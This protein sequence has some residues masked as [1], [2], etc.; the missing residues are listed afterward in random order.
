MKKKK[1]VMSAKLTKIGRAYSESVKRK[2]VGEI[3][4]GLLSHREASKKYGV[5]RKSIGN[6]ITQLSLLNL[7]PLEIAR[8]T[9][10]D[11]KEDNKNRILAKQVLDLTKELEKSKLRISGLETMIA[12]SEQEL[13]IKIRKKS[14]AKQSRK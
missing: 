3:N 14:G 11:M 1:V 6:W 9:M 7:K 4:C 13:N 5:N 2:I 8:N 12:V 10:V